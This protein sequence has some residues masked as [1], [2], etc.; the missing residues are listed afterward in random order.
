LKIL[1]QNGV[2]ILLVV[3]SEKV[4]IGLITDGDIRRHILQKGNLDVNVIEIANTDYFYLNSTNVNNAK[5]FFKK[6]NSIS[7]IPIIDDN[8]HINALIVKDDIKEVDNNNSQIPVV[9]MAGGKG[10]RLLPLTKIIPKPLVPIGSETMLEKIINNLNGS[11][12]NKF[13]VIINYKKELIKSYMNEVDYSYELDFIEESEYYGTVGGLTL[14]KGKIEGDFILSNCDI[15]SFLNYSALLDWHKSHNAEL[16]VLGV[17]KRT[18]IPYGVLEVDS[19]SYV[20]KIIEKPHLHNIIVSGIYVVNS[21]VLDEIPKD[22]SFGMDELITKLTSQGKKVTC[23]PIDD[24]WHDI[25]QF[26]EYREFLKSFKDL[27]V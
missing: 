7:H 20:T 12:F 24:G 26:S 23:Y 2:Q 17:R 4:L 1:D 15:I 18:D 22:R 14:L 25:G 6:Q 8:C 16:T 11:G 13:N 5:E 27:N 10:T 21:S 19:E 9:I 3:N